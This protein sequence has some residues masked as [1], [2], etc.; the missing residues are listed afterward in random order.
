MYQNISHDFKTPLTVIKSY[1]EGI[2]DGIQDKDQGI[3]VIKEQVNKLEMK[4]H[5][6]L[7]LNKLNYLKEK[8]F[9]ILCHRHTIHKQ[10]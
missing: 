8:N 10:D 1:I 9:G 4:V 7:Y 5:S 6:L 3:K 2:E